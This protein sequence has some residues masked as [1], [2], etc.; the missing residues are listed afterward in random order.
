MFSWAL[1]GG[2]RSM[3][4]T[5]GVRETRERVPEGVR[6]EGGGQA[7]GPCDA[8]AEVGGERPSCCRCDRVG[9]TRGPWLVEQE[10]LGLMGRRRNGSCRRAGSE[11]S[12]E[13]DEVLGVRRRQGEVRCVKQP[14]CRLVGVGALAE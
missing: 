3:C 7:V 10:G 9:K 11:K 1:Q 4:A 14:P 5:G 8:R 2:D 13:R 12:R 6:A